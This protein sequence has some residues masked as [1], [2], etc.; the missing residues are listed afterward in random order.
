MS[1]TSISISGPEQVYRANDGYMSDGGEVFKFA[2]GSKASGSACGA[3][4]DGYLSEGGASLYARKIQTRIAIEKQKAAEEQRLKHGDLA[5][6]RSRPLPGL[7]DVLGSGDKIPICKSSSASN[8]VNSPAAV[9]RVVGGRKVQKNDSGIQTDD[10]FKQPMVKHYDWKQA[11]AHNARVLTNQE[12][13]MDEYLKR[14]RAAAEQLLQRERAKPLMAGNRQLSAPSE[15]AST[16]ATPTGTRRASAGPPSSQGLERGGSL[17]RGYGASPGSQRKVYESKRE[18]GSRSLPKG[19]TSSLTY[20]LMLDRIQQ[21]RQHRPPKVANDGSL[22][23]SN[24]ATYGGWLQPASTY[25]SGDPWGRTSDVMG[26]NESLNS[27]SSSIQAARANSLT[28]ARLLIHQQQHEQQMLTLKEPSEKSYASSSTTR[29]DETDYYG[30]V[31]KPAEPLSAGIYGS[32][33][34]PSEKQTDAAI[35][36]LR[37]NLLEEHEKVLSLTTQL[38]TNAQVV[39]AFEQSLANMTS[40][41]QQITATAERK[42]SELAE[43]RHTIDRLRQSGAD[44]GLIK[45]IGLGDRQKSSDSLMTK[46]RHKRSGWLRNSFSKAFSKD[47]RQKHKGGS[48]SDAEDGSITNRLYEEECQPPRPASA[49]SGEPRKLSVTTETQ[50]NTEPE[51]VNELRRQLMEK[52]SQLTETRLEALSSAHQLESLRETVTKMRTELM[53]LKSDNERLQHSAQNTGSDTGTAKSIASSHSSLNVAETEDRRLSTATSLSDASMLSSNATKA[54]CGPSTL[55]LSATTDPTNKDGG[56]LVTVA[57]NGTVRIGTVA[58]SGKSNWELLDSLV[59]RL[60]QEYVMRL[61]PASNLGLTANESIHSYQVGE[62]SRRPGIHPNPELLPYGYLVGEAVDIRINLTHGV[63]ET[64][65]DTLAFETAIP[66]QMLQRCVGMLVDHNRL[67]LSGPAGTGKT[68]LAHK[69]AGFLLRKTGGSSYRL[70]NASSAAVAT[71]NVGLNNES[72]LKEFLARV[73]GPNESP[74]VVIVDNLHRVSKLDDVFEVCHHNPDQYIIGTFDAEGSASSPTSGCVGSYNFRWISLSCQVEPT[75]GMLARVL[76]QRVLNVETKTR[77]YDG[78]MNLI[79]DFLI[80]LQSYLNR[81]EG[82]LVT[83]SVFSSC[84]ITTNP[85]QDPGAYEASKRWFVQVWNESVVPKIVSGVRE[86]I[87]MNPKVN[88]AS[89]WQDPLQFVLEHWPWQRRTQASLMEPHHKQL[90]ASVRA[91]DLGLQSDARSDD[92]ARPISGDAAKDPL[93]NM[94]IHLQDAACNNE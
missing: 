45:Q 42:D 27:V 40:R 93:Y 43:L 70:S 37:K 49:A 6:P 20:G 19:A 67:I 91:E 17:E 92:G 3:V 73:T 78:E 76:R 10:S 8:V 63:G 66:K 89:D 22:S 90:L 16:P 38:A 77:I 5:G 30:I 12:K 75:R 84:P 7:P 62:I 13:A 25:A 23:D 51:V 31:R 44:A 11:M 71:Y 88:L 60:F 26:S 55:D 87:A 29:K 83:P 21:K 72:G 85:G 28:K 39:Q 33:V 58:V 47:K 46:D 94:L 34:T 65:V 53:S 81:M 64:A 61:D 50:V 59:H 48:L 35:N 9:Y 24:Y 1:T 14:Q 56:K 52:D 82:V 36:L 86:V 32:V 41:L 80:K 68:F 74:K 54:E 4:D 57:V 69:I 2:N 15:A 18:F 79:V